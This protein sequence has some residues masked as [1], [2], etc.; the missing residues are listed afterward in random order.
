MM[1]LLTEVVS[2]IWKAA[3]LNTA[4]FVPPPG[5]V[6]GALAVAASASDY[7]G[8]GHPSPTV[9]APTHVLSRLAAF[10]EPRGLWFGCDHIDST[11]PGR[12]L[13]LWSTPSGLA[14]LSASRL[15]RR[16]APAVTVAEV[17]RSGAAA[18]GAVGAGSHPDGN[19]G[20]NHHLPTAEG[21]A[22]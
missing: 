8:G 13:S 4:S 6:S 10:R 1:R 2:I 22:L 20:D 16:D 7:Q 18:S 19:H 12:Y 5:P 3:M 14:S 21:D 17:P 11:R 9:F 15:A